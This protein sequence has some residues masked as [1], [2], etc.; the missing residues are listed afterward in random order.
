[1]ETHQ[2]ISFLRNPYG[3]STDEMREI[4][5]AAAD[6]IEKWKNAYENMRDWGIK[7]GIDVN[8]YSIHG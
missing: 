8:A 6:E 3:K 5:L 7:C 2:I 1:M 4:R